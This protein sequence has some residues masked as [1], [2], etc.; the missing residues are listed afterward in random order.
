MNQDMLTG[1]NRLYMQAKIKKE[2]AGGGAC[3][4]PN[5]SWLAFLTRLVTPSVHPPPLPLLRYGRIRLL[6]RDRHTRLLEDMRLTLAITIP[7]PA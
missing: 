5:T 2:F 7:V 1:Q 4:T 6:P 3:K